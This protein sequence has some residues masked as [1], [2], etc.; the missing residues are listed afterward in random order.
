MNG[1]YEIVKLP[2]KPKKGDKFYCI[3]FIDDGS[4]GIGTE[5]NTW[6]G[7]SLNY[8][9]LNAGLLYRTRKEADVHLHEDYKN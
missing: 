7:T 5:T 6:H 3:S 4:K 1:T 8:A 9:M 2:W